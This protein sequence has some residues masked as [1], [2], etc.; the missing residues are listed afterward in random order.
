MNDVTGGPAA[1]KRTGKLRTEATLLPIQ[2]IAGK[3]GIPPESVEPSGITRRRSP[4]ISSS[5]ASPTGLMASSFW[6]RRINPPPA[7]EGK[8]TT[9]VGLGDALN[10]K[11]KR[12]AICLREPSLGPCFGMKGGAAGGRLCPG[13]PD[14]AELNSATSTGDF[15]AIGVANNLLAALVDNHIYWGNP[16]DI[17]AADQ[18]LAALSRYERRPFARSSPPALAVFRQTV[19]PARM[20]STSPSLR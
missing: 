7:G 3:L 11:G 4:W 14:G 2:D 19:S 12:T 16:L 18:L 10:R 1:Q 15:H 6:S 8:T 5:G 17:R 20:D 13:G 9:T